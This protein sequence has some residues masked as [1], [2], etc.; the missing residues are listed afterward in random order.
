MSI[1]AGTA[2]AGMALRALRRRT[3]STSAAATIEKMDTCQRNNIWAT[4]GRFASAA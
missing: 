3:T 4:C 1:H 2:G